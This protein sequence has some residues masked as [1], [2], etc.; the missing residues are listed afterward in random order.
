VSREVTRRIRETGPIDAAYYLSAEIRRR[1][2]DIPYNTPIEIRFH[3]PSG[4]DYSGAAL[5]A[6]EVAV[7]YA[8]EWTEVGQE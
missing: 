1:H 5:G 6:D 4:G 2:P 7:T 3:I 8:V